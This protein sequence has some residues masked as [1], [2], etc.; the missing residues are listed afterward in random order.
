MKKII[1]GLI[2]GLV[3]AFIVY[4]D[5]N[6][7]VVQLG[8]NDAETN[9][10]CQNNGQTGWT[11]TPCTYHVYIPTVPTCESDVST[12]ITGQVCTSTN[13]INCYYYMVTNG[14][15]DGVEC[16]EGQ[17]DSSTSTTNNV[18]NYYTTPCL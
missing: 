2:A 9:S 5:C 3:I 14:A 1:L 18:P 17:R 15:C 6:D 4:A 11:N 8:T 7:T 16:H 10:M 13:N 12:N